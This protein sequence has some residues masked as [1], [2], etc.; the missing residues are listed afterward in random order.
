MARVAKKGLDYFPLDV[1]F[2]LNR[3]IRRLMRKHEAT[4]ITGVIA[5]YTQ[6]YREQGY[7]LIWNED[8]CFDL[9]EL[10]N[11]DMIKMQAFIADAIRTELFDAEQFK[12]NGILTSVSIQEQYKACT[13]KRKT[14]G[15]EEKYRLI[16][17][18][19]NDIQAADHEEDANQSVPVIPFP[20]E[21]IPIKASELQQSKE[22]EK[23]TETKSN[24]PCIP[25]RNGGDSEP[26]IGEV[27]VEG[28]WVPEYCMN[29][30][31]HNC[32][33]LL[34]R[35]AEIR[36]RDEKEIAAILKLSN[37]GRIGHP[38]WSII[39]H[40]RWPKG[41]LIKLPGRFILSQLSRGGTT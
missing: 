8:T 15:I 4:A 3:K 6:I 1:N 25:S 9:C 32:D 33:G 37:Y 34:Y 22:K 23:K 36:V 40:S 11:T 17:E 20:A 16:E 26:K 28:R 30:R 35:L 41:N 39:S 18:I 29:K 10:V 12:K 38:V 14:N 19:Q 27:L 13:V 7:Y 31:T 5:L 2:L 24:L 21:D